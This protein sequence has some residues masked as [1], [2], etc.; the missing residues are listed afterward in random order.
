M[1]I[2]IS[3]SMHAHHCHLLYINNVSQLATLIN[4]TQNGNFFHIILQNLLGRM[5][6]CV[7]VDKHSLNMLL[8]ISL[9]NCSVKLRT[10]SFFSV[11][12]QK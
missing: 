4:V 12:S 2:F 6:D 7:S 8:K 10:E 1:L 9:K 5:S 3:A 11:F